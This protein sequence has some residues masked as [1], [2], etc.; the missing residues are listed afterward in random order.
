M[1]GHNVEG[2]NRNSLLFLFQMAVI[3]FILI[4]LKEGGE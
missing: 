2:L 4:S 1:G 3:E